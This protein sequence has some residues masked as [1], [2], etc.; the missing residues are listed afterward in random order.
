M[1]K[2]PAPPA[3]LLTVCSWHESHG[4]DVPPPGSLTCMPACPGWGHAVAEAKGKVFSPVVKLLEGWGRLRFSLRRLWYIKTLP[5]RRRW[6][7]V[8]CSLNHHD[9][10]TAP[11]LNVRGEMDFSKPGRYFRCRRAHCQVFRGQLNLWASDRWWESN[12][13]LV[14]VRRSCHECHGRG[15]SGFMRL[16]GGGRCGVPCKC[17]RVQPAYV[18][19]VPPTL[20]GPSPVGTPHAVLKEA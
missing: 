7:K 13:F 6:G 14:L 19:T 20:A 12:D 9:W 11:S 2:L 3:K 17:I 5:L 8:L 16:P 18:E 1:S 10:E 4:F 15:Y